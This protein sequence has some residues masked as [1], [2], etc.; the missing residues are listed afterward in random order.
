M[1]PNSPHYVATLEAA[2]C[3][4]GHF[5]AMSA[6]RDTIFGLFH[7]FA[8]SRA[9]TNT[10]HTKDACLLLQRLVIYTHHI[11]VRGKSDTRN[12]E[13][14]VGAHVPQV[15]TLQGTI[16]LFLLCIVIVRKQAQSPSK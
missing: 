4:G 11:L 10:D 8:L 12:P 16:D 7:M 13:A 5:Y 1:R 2:I 15:S 9:I 14:V 6:I 3:H